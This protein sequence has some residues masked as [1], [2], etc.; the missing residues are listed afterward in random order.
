LQAGEEGMA[1]RKLSTFERLTR[2]K[3]NR[4]QRKE[5]MRQ[6]ST[7]DPGLE[8]VHRDAGGIDVGNE[9]HFAAVP[10]G[11]ASASVREFGCWTG[12]L[13]QMAEW[14]I[15]CGVKTVAMQSTGVYW[16]AVYDVLV[17]AGLEVWLVNARDTKN[18]PGR[19]SDVQESQW[20]M[21]LHTYGL[22]RKS[23]VPAEEIRAVRTIWRLRERHVSDASREI[24]HIQKALTTMNVQLANVISDISGTTGQAIIRAILSGERDT[25][26]LARLKNY[27]AHATEEEIAA[28]LDGNWQEDVL[29]E[30]QQSVDRYDFCHQ[31]IR[32]CDEQL[33]K[34]LKALPERRIGG[35]NA[36]A[37]KE[38]G[39]DGSELSPTSKRKRK[40]PRGNEPKFEQRA[41][42][43]RI[44]GVDL[45]SIDGVGVMVAQTWVSEI[46]PDVSAWPTEDHMVS[47]LKLSPNK[48]ITG[49]KVIK[50]SKS[51]NKTT[52]RLTTVLRT[53][54]CTLRD[55]DS[56]LGAKFR[57]WRARMEPGAA[58]K[59][60]AA[61]LARL[62]YRLLTRGR[63]W[64][65]RG[66]RE[67]ENRR[68]ER[69]RS[70][71]QRKAAS[72]GYR[73]EPV[74]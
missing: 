20:L 43:K 31:Q 34:Y 49:G 32:A 27:R 26:K 29:F 46:G 4:K 40:S 23:F 15:A 64:V 38:D 61:E 9:S 18:L 35:G 1:K 60:M 72:L 11:R 57:Q 58:V 30:M 2:G 68:R 47:W 56:Y 6:V 33:E 5:L 37:A 50:G 63:E 41:E 36:A 69:D 22:L 25:G 17:K 19:K 73:L 21:K 44:C 8:V 62:I 51:K 39:S 24:Q 52:N 55:S 3:L 7:D 74:A 54:A 16:I 59:A 10:P 66:A 45:T 13:R 53:A 70:F 28:S 14:F 42:L 65:D 48:P 12:D 71:L 67:Q